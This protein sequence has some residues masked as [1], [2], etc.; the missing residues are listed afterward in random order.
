MTS[1]ARQLAFSAATACFALALSASPA[2]AKTVHHHKHH[3]KPH[4]AHHAQSSK[5]S[6]VIRI[7]QEH[8]SHLGYY[9]GTA[10]GIMGAQTKAAIKRFQK[11]HQ[12]KADGALGSKTNR[13]LALADQSVAHVAAS[14]N[15]SF[16]T[17]DVAI[18]SDMVNG[19]VN[20]DYTASMNGGS[21]SVPS[22][23]A[24]VDVSENATGA[25]KTYNVTVNGQP[26][27]VADDQTA[28]IGVSATFDLGNEDAIVFTTY[29]PA[30]SACPYKNHV[31]ALNSTGNKLL[32]VNNCTRSYQAQVNN[33]SLYLTFPEFS[34]NRAIGATWR[35]EG[36][37]VER[38]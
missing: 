12:L 9:N 18:A 6:A 37:R 17:H 27:L 16:A 38:L 23:F 35:I 15:F 3:A 36:M 8:L 10:D 25:N 31:L 21:K 32:E 5:G 34:D 30:N 24:R 29:S 22:R 20:P 28:V 33:G 13:A 26:L 2:L 7:A 4:H 1:F 11:E 19:A 14:K